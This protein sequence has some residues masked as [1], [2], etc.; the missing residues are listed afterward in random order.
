MTKFAPKS[1]SIVCIDSQYTLILCENYST[2]YILHN[3]IINNSDLIVPKSVK[4]WSS[5]NFLI[6]LTTAT[7]PY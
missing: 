6:F 4:Y 1:I 5:L 3:I 7:I 2:T